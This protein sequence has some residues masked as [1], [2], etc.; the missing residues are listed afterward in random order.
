[1]EEREI[2]EKYENGMSLNAIAREYKTYPSTIS[3]ILTKARSK[4]T[5]RRETKWRTVCTKRRKVN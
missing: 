1:M 4:V 2:I 3:R 5:T